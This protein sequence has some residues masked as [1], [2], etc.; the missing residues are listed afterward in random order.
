MKRLFLVLALMLTM[1]QAFAQSDTQYMTT[2]IVISPFE[3]A[4]KMLRSAT[5]FSK[6]MFKATG[7]I[8][9][10]G[11][12]GREQLKDEMLALN[13]E[14]MLGK[15]LVIGQLNQPAL[16]ELF[17][18]IAADEVKMEE[19]NAIVPHGSELQRIATVL[20]LE[21]FLN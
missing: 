17:T 20:A 21:L 7:L 3:L 2:E 19:I 12:A 11:V 15:K 1:G 14:M 6:E 10:R 8:Q 5:D 16:N 9:G 4:S 13:E 18:E